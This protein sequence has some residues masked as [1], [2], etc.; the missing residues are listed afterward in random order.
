MILSNPIYNPPPIFFESHAFQLLIYPKSF[1]LAAFYFQESP[2]PCPELSHTITCYIP[3]QHHNQP[4]VHNAAT[5]PEFQDNSTSLIMRK[6]IPIPIF[7]QVLTS[8][9]SPQ[10]TQALIVDYGAFGVEIPKSGC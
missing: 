7:P 6:K 10:V 3:L 8:N 2:E 9:T 5:T 1:T 4:T